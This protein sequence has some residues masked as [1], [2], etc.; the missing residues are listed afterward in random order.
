MLGIAL[1]LVPLGLSAV[2]YEL[3]H[4]QG[5]AI[6]ILTG[7]FVA[8]ALI[9]FFWPWLV[10]AWAWLRRDA[11]LR[12]A[13][14]SQERLNTKLHELEQERAELEAENE[15]LIARGQPDKLVDTLEEWLKT[16]PLT[17][18]PNQTYRNDRIELDGFFYERCTFEDCTFF[19]KGEKPF[20]VS[21]DSTVKGMVNIDARGPQLQ[22]LLIFM[23]QLG[24][25][26]PNS[27]WYDFHDGR[28]ID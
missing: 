25:L 13:R 9:V 2:G 23:K 14:E 11:E 21:A 18:V 20:R 10:A 4:K 27:Q 3:N 7:L 22:A 28:L 1:A 5:Y 8:G 12:K 19:F 16:T 24:A 15:E 6:L 17:T 26:H